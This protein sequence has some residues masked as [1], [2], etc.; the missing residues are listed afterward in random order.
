MI[1]DIYT[2]FELS[3]LAK[4]KGF[5]LASVG[6]HTYN[7]YKDD[8]FDGNIQ[9]GHMYLDQPAIVPLSLLQR[10]L[11]MEHNL[12]IDIRSNNVA[13]GKYF[14]CVTLTIAPY[15]TLYDSNKDVCVYHDTYEGALIKGLEEG[16]KLIKT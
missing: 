2:P 9:W 13:L 10:W 14:L 7:Y 11:R 15:H 4:E 6:S 12:H 8:G 16:L 5:T 3:K 1:Y